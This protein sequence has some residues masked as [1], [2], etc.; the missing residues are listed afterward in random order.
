MKTEKIICKISQLTLTNGKV[1]KLGDRISYHANYGTRM[2]TI[3]DLDDRLLR[4]RIKWD[5]Q[6]LRTWIR[7]QA[8]CKL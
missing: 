8:L 7:I 6:K 3:I 5:E 1:Y 2:G 4:A